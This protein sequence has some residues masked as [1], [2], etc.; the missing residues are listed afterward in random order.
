ME[1]RITTGIYGGSFNPI[2]NGHTQLGIGLHR[3]GLVDE[4]WFV[5]SPHNPHK[6]QKDLL[7]DEERL[8]LARLAVTETPYL[9]V[10]DVEFHLPRPSYMVN[11]LETLRTQYPQREFIL[12]MGADNWEKFSHWYRH[13][14]IMR[15]HRIIVYPRPGYTL[16]DT[17]SQVTVADTPLI[18]ISSTEIRKQIH[19]GTFR[20]DGIHP[21]VWKEIKIKGYYV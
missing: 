10:S 16:Q 20:G 7:N 14:E 6:Q 17:P 11:T 13:E 19:E 21:S 3:Q 12:V 9:K 18:P 4:L 5:V 2:H 15:H 1:K 8:N